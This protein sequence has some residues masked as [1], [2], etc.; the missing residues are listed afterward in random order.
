M[1]KFKSMFTDANLPRTIITLMFLLL[2]VGVVAYG[3]P[4]P[5]YISD[6]LVRFGMN[7]ILVLAMVP[8]IQSGI[9]PNF[10]VTIGVIAG[11][12]GTIISLDLPEWIPLPE[13][14]THGFGG[15]LLALIITIPI[16]T[17]V[18]ILFG[19]MLN[20]VKGSEMIVSNYTGFSIVSVMSIGWLVIPFRTVSMKWPIGDGLINVITMERTFGQYLND[21]L[22]L[23]F[24]DVSGET[25]VLFNKNIAYL[26]KTFD[27]E[28]RVIFHIPV[29]LLLFFFFAC[30][31][32]YLYTKSKSG[33]ANRAVGDSMEFARA[34]GINVDR[35]R[36]IGATLSTVLGAVG[37]IIF[38]QAFGF[39]Q[40]YQAPLMMAYPAVASILIGGATASRASIS[41]V[42]IGAFLFNGILTIALPVANQ[43]I[44]EG[45]LSEVFR[46]IVQ[47]GVILYALTKVGGKSE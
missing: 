6:I 14:F 16:A 44:P 3:L 28:Y 1:N 8:A 10:G 23:K 13:F 19:K 41:N 35:Q 30:F 39:I 21:L 32:V 12:L 26:Q 36:V 18:G 27:K 9:G 37:I 15:L 43:M 20:K 5:L 7:G 42:I 46:M 17:A 22:S 11:L 34:S 47:N 38:S 40:L 2:C 33:I 25:V 31:L 24:L 29:G 4:L 45:D